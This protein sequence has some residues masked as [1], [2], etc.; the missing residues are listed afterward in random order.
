VAI[1]GVF[2]EPTPETYHLYCR[3]T[4]FQTAAALVIQASAEVQDVSGSSLD[5]SDSTFEFRS[6]NLEA[7]GAP[8]VRKQ[9][10]MGTRVAQ[11]MDLLR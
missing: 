1:T 4:V 8:F 9:T 3:L 6:S 2:R 10:S 7:N 11:A 5:D